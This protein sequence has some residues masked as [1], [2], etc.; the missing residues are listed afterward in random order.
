[1]SSILV[2]VLIPRRVRGGVEEID[3]EADL[4]RLLRPYS[5]DTQVTEYATR[6][7]CV[8]QSAARKAVEAGYTDRPDKKRSVANESD[9]KA[10][11]VSAKTP[12]GPKSRRRT[13]EQR[14][15]IPVFIKDPE[16]LYVDRMREIVESVVPDDDCE[17]CG[18]TGFVKSTSTPFGRLDYWNIGGLSGRKDLEHAIERTDIIRAQTDV[19][20]VCELDL[21]SLTP[22]NA[23]VT[24]DGSWH[25]G[26]E[27]FWGWRAIIIDEDWDHRFKEILEQYW[28]H[29]LVAV[30]CH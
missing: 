26:E 15:T 29:N 27:A 10:N 20:P 1:M 16:G 7:R 25:A 11:D 22:P 30:N 3:V 2:Y 28:D 14:P 12:I 24:P 17:E 21:E 23:V 6:C 9:S 4:N 13:G 19:I 5:F 8:Y 18:G